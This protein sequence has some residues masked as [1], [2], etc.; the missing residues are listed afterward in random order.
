M[1]ESWLNNLIDSENFFGA[2]A[3][4]YEWQSSVHNEWCSITKV[5]FSFN[6]NNLEALTVTEFIQI[7]AQ[8]YYKCVHPPEYLPSSCN[9]CFYTFNTSPSHRG[10]CQLNSLLNIEQVGFQCTLECSQCRASLLDQWSTN[11]KNEHYRFNGAASD[12][13]KLRAA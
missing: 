1:Q 6:T 10:S 11:N 3:D 13:I 9:F 8:M 12:V 2:R 5:I 4:S 7:Q